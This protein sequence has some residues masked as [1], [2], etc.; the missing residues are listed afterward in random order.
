MSEISFKFLPLLANDYFR[1]AFPV[2]SKI[3]NGCTPEGYPCRDITLKVDIQICLS[4]V[5]Q[6]LTKI[7]ASQYIKGNISS[8]CGI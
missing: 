5:T 1:S 7:L 6:R 2:F 4:F 3:I 8:C